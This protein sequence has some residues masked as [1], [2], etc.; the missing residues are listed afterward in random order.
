MDIIV[1]VG[2]GSEEEII[3]KDRKMIITL[4]ACQVKPKD[5]RRE[6]ST[7]YFVFE[8]AAASEFYEKYLSG[9]RID[10]DISSFWRSEDIF[11]SYLNG[12]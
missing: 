1:G 3:T 8:K 7:L 10:I 4:M 12:R 11:K 5:V 9:E 6:N 2:V